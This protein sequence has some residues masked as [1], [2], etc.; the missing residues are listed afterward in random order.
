[1]PDVSS[2][3]DIP[4]TAIP[5]PV[6]YERRHLRIVDGPVM[7]KIRTA[8]GEKLRGAACTVDA[9]EHRV[10]RLQG[11][12]FSASVHVQSMR[13]REVM[14]E[15]L[16]VEATTV[17]GNDALDMLQS[18]TET[19]SNLRALQ[20]TTTTE[21]P[22]RAIMLRERQQRENALRGLLTS[23]AADGNAA[24]GHLLA[25]ILRHS[26]PAYDFRRHAREQ[27]ALVADIGDGTQAMDAVAFLLRAHCV[28]EDA[29]ERQRE[30]RA[31]LEELAAK[32]SLAKE[33]LTTMLKLHPAPSTTEGVPVAP[34]VLQVG[35][36]KAAKSI[37]QLY[38][39]MDRPGNAIALAALEKLDA[40][41]DLPGTAQVIV[42]NA[43][44][45]S[46]LASFI[47]AIEK[48]SLPPSA[49][50]RDTPAATMKIIHA[51]GAMSR[52]QRDRILGLST[53]LKNVQDQ[54]QKLK[55][56]K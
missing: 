42:G 38:A 16:I 17:D 26:N 55:E 53:R 19:A 1:M 36:G 8:F 12:G 28:T 39:D 30:I 18:T 34:A 25:G 21:D 4:P 32:P 50:G 49:R 2:Q 24:A 47:S 14:G 48:A 54:V 7:T 41:A 9:P 29:L 51:L 33:W 43:Q 44:H 40:L 3:T 20:E 6:A 5:V 10:F 52:T 22:R 15:L 31:L 37:S 13:V 35:S 46:A 56:K 23:A 27:L 45:E 11:A